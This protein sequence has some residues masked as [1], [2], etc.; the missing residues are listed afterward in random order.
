MLRP[1]ISCVLILAAHT[2]SAQGITNPA[3]GGVIPVYLLTLLGL[4]LLAYALFSIVKRKASGKI[5]AP[6]IAFPLITLYLPAGFVVIYAADH[7]DGALYLYLELLLLMLGMIVLL[8]RGTIARVLGVAGLLIFVAALNFLHPKLVDFQDRLYI[9]NEKDF[10]FIAVSYPGH[11]REMHLSDGRVLLNINPHRHFGGSMRMQARANA[12]ASPIVLGAGDEAA[13]PI[14]FDIFEPVTTQGTWG[15]NK[16][17]KAF[18]TIPI[19]G[20]IHISRIEAKPI[21]KALLLDDNMSVECRYLY[22]ARGASM[23]NSA[24]G[25]QVVWTREQTVE[26]RSVVDCEP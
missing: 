25:T 10:T 12:I 3:G 16:R 6:F 7:F 17:P 11:W 15:W 19:L 26:D 13:H 8:W 23:P 1:V 4:P 21:G 20:T 22:A 14:I 18:L 24:I 5:P 9:D 2:T